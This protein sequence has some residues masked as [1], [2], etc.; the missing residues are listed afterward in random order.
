MRTA[1]QIILVT[2]LAIACGDRQLDG[3]SGDGEPQLGTPEWSPCVTENEGLVTCAEIC[4]ASGTVCVANACVAVPTSCKP[5]SCDM[6][7]SNLGLGNGICS[8]PL[9]GGFVAAPCEDPVEFIF[10]DTARCCCAEEL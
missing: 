3:D 1:L 8:D 5:D 6:A 4:A 7:T 9:V 10:N 2:T